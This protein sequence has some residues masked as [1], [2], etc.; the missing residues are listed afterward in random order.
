MS[1]ITDWSANLVTCGFVGLYFRFRIHIILVQFLDISFRVVFWEVFICN[2]NNFKSLKL[3]INI[4]RNFK[5]PQRIFSL[6]TQK[7]SFLFCTL[8]GERHIEKQHV[9][10]PGS[11]LL[12]IWKCFSIFMPMF[13]LI[14]QRYNSAE[15]VIKLKCIVVFAFC[16]SVLWQDMTEEE[17]NHLAVLTRQGFINKA[18]HQGTTRK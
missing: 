4:S 1:F 6:K 5:W 10:R 15:S 11:L 13:P 16:F 9:R 7:V 18:E 14:V 17:T 3:W 8:L 2:G 12:D